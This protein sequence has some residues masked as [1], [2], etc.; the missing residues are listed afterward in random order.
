[1]IPIYRL[2]WTLLTCFVLVPTDAWMVFPAGQKNAMLATT[3][4]TTSSTTSRL[5]YFEDSSS[6][7]SP[8][9]SDNSNNGNSNNNNNNNNEN[10]DRMQ[11][12]RALQ[13]AFYKPSH[14]EE[15]QEKTQ[16]LD[17]FTGI[18]HNLPLWRVQWNEVP[19]RTNV[20]NVHEV[21]CM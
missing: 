5:Y 21:C 10:M 15:E 19:G 16:R 18:F 8:E 6:S 2:T 3:R 11:A 20:L 12:V 13:A 9:N 7:R 14:D 1:M 4:R 17:L